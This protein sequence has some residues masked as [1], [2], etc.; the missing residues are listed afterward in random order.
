MNY[1]VS[2]TCYISAQSQELHFTEKKCMR[3]ETEFL[4]VRLV[5]ILNS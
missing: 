2:A 1:L 5:L 4:S 3:K